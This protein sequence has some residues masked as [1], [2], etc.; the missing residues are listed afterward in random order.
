[1]HHLFLL[2]AYL[3][4][5]LGL[6]LLGQDLRQGFLVELSVVVSCLEVLHEHLFEVVGAFEVGVQSGESLFEAGGMELEELLK[7][8]V[9]PHHFENFVPG[10]SLVSYALPLQSLHLLNQT[11]LE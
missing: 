4:Q 2:L 11:F 6:G 8:L 7:V 10:D 5:C 3:F 1:M 9:G